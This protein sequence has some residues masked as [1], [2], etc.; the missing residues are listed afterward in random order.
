MNFIH[1]GVW[2]TEENKCYFPKKGLFTQGLSAEAFGH[3]HDERKE[4]KSGVF[5][6]VRVK[7]TFHVIAPLTPRSHMYAKAQKHMHT[8]QHTFTHTH[9]YWYMRR[10]LYRP[11][12]YVVFIRSKGSHDILW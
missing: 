2:R 5:R 7:N 4:S 8:A 9:A 3:D 10:S 6:T 11:T 1:F 12:S